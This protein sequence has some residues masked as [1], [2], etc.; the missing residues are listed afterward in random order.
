MVATAMP[1][2]FVD[3]IEGSVVLNQTVKSDSLYGISGFDVKSLRQKDF[4]K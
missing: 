3:F 1:R 4:L 2:C